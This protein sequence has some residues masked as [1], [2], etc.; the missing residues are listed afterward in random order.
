M[1][2]C[3]VWSSYLQVTTVDPVLIPETMPFWSTVAT[4]VLLLVHVHAEE[5]SGHLGEVGDERWQNLLGRSG[6]GILLLRCPETPELTH[7]PLT[8]PRFTWRG[9]LSSNQR[10]VTPEDQ[11]SCIYTSVG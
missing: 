11:G 3:T 7:R 6:R 2:A 5:I 9:E 10:R 8:G 1:L 4:D